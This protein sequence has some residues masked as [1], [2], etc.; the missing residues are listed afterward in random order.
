MEDS[1]LELGSIQSKLLHAFYTQNAEY[2]PSS[3]LPVPFNTFPKIFQ[4]IDELFN[5]APLAD[6]KSPED[7][8]QS[9]FPPFSAGSTLR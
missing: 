6:H 4:N 2:P 3:S 7:Q 5:H 1:G 8:A 9:C